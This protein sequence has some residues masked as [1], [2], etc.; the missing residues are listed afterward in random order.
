MLFALCI[1]IAAGIAQAQRKEVT[2]HFEGETLHM[3]TWKKTVGDLLAEAQ[4]EPAPED[5]IKPG[6]ESQLLDGMEIRVVRARPVE[7]A[8]DGR[9]FTS[10]TPLQKPQ[11]ILEAAGV[12]LQTPDRVLIQR[13]GDGVAGIT[14]Q[15][16]KVETETAQIELDFDTKTKNDPKLAQGKRSIVQEGQTGLLEKTYQVTYVDGV[17][18]ARKLLGEE[19]VRKPQEK[20]IAV[21]TKV[22]PAREVASRGS[23]GV[24]STQVGVA[25][26]YGDAFAGRRTASGDIFDPDALTAAHPKLHSFKLPVYARV[27]YLKTG[28][29]VKVR[30]NDYGPSTGGRIIDLSRA[31]AEAIGLKAHGIGEVRVEI[32][33]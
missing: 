26:W 16:V 6:T 28:K 11:S 5:L 9:R 18:E 3:Q 24:V 25:S 33:R 13:E 4:F 22:E 21:G 10:L 27:T 31:A 14:V 2:I 20:V 30:I 8:V 17:E 15:R 1:L 23:Q 12:A 32:L 19:T 29:S 7:I